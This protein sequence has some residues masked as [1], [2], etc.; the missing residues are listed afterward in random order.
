MLSWDIAAKFKKES[1]KKWFCVE[2]RA[3]GGISQSY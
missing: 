3:V 2:F 1:V